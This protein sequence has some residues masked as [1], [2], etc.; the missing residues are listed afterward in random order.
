MASAPETATNR[1]DAKGCVQVVDKTMGK[2]CGKPR[3]QELNV[4][5]Q[6]A[7]S[8]DMK[9]CIKKVDGRW[10]CGSSSGAKHGQQGGTFAC[11]ST[12]E[13]WIAGRWTGDKTRMPGPDDTNQPLP[14]TPLMGKTK[15]YLREYVKKE[16]EA[17]CTKNPL[18]EECR[19]KS[20]QGGTGR[21]G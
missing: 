14:E 13:I 5:N 11:E 10:A 12:G 2:R 1:G 21:R 8:V 3:S 20:S 15:G 4:R 16:H 18:A 19:P 7:E 17:L 9:F 6:C